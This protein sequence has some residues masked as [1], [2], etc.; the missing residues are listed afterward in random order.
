MLR[1]LRAQVLRTV[2]AAMKA[3]EE[4][5]DGGGPNG[6]LN[7]RLSC[8]TLSPMMSVP[9]GVFSTREKRPSSNG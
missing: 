5:S 7:P 8:A 1:K 9:S 2:E 4:Q 6:I 3:E